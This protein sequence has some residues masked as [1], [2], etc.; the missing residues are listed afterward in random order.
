MEEKRGVSMGGRGE[1]GGEYGV[2]G[3][4]TYLDLCL[5][6][7]CVCDCVC[8]CVCVIVPMI[9]TDTQTKKK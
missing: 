3:E 2:K 9:I 7:E 8:V 5:W 4:D 6:S 1:E